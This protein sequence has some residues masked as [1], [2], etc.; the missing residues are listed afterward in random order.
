MGFI[1]FGLTLGHCS[2]AVEGGTD[3]RQWLLDTRAVD[4][5]CWFYL[6]IYLFREREIILYS[7]VDA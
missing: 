2:H 1:D 3:A 4:D 5:W 6:F 7:L